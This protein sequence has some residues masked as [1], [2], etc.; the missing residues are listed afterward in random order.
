M[1]IL[2][3]IAS[4]EAFEKDEKTDD[5]VICECGNDTFR[6]YSYGCFGTSMYCSKCGKGRTIHGG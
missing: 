2:K 4:D 6:N 5:K 3:E 1:V